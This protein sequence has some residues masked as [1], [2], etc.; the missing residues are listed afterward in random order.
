MS[1]VNGLV[2]TGTSND[3]FSPNAA[4][5]RAMLTTVLWRLESGCTWRWFNE[6]PYR[7]V[8]YTWYT[9]AL[10]WANH[11]KIVNGTSETKFSPNGSITREQ[12]ATMLYR[13]AGYKKLDTSK[14]AELT[15]FADAKK[16]SSYAETAVKWAVAEGI[17]AGTEKDSTAYLDP[18][19][20]ANRAQVATMLQRFCDD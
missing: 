4:M 20:N 6:L 9:Q 18:Q 1:A 11:C 2:M 15:K 5:T 3:T 13:Y 10:R 17:I 7:D 14:Q 12:L 16:V 8:K 19:G